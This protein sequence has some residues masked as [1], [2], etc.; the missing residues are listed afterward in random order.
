M[1]AV[2]RMTEKE[3]DEKN[4][5]FKGFPEGKAMR[6]PYPGFLSALLPQIDHLAS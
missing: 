2:S 6:F 1:R 5:G 3:L 4:L